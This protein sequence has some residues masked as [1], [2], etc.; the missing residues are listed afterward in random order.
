MTSY[1]A[2]GDLHIGH[3]SYAGSGCRPASPYVAPPCLRGSGFAARSTSTRQFAQP[4]A[5]RPSGCEPAVAGRAP[6]PRGPYPPLLRRTPGGQGAWI[7]PTTDTKHSARFGEHYGSARLAPASLRTAGAP[8]ASSEAT[9]PSESTSIAEGVLIA[10]KA[11]PAA[12]FWFKAAGEL[13][14]MWL[15]ASSAPAETKGALGHPSAGSPP[16]SFRSGIIC[17]QKPHPEFHASTIVSSPLESS[18][19]TVSPWRF[20]PLSRGLVRQPPWLP[21]LWGRRHGPCRSLGTALLEGGGASL[22][23]GHAPPPRAPGVL[24]CLN[25]AD[26]RA[27]DLPV[28]LN[29]GCAWDAA[30]PI[31]LRDLPGL[32]QIDKLRGAVNSTNPPSKK[33][34]RSRSVICVPCSTYVAPGARQR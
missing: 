32:L 4:F 8:T 34:T 21:G 28:G 26:H 33:P 31:G 17:W 27:S 25:P 16:N 9:V 3:L 13:V 12:K 15:L 11:R 10:S 5:P 30:N 20:G 23:G 2:K 14:R 19:F 29:E 7:G 6:L 22:I 18:S 1:P 24:L